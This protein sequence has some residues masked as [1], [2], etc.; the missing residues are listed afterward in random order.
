MFEVCAKL[1]YKKSG[2]YNNRRK[3]SNHRDTGNGDKCYNI[4]SDTKKIKR[5]TELK[6]M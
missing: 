3:Y 5:I 1:P 6:E 2:N 4:N